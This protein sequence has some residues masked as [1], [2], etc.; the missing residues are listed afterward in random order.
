MRIP[1]VAPATLSVLRQSQMR[2]VLMVVAN[3]FG[4]QSLEVPNSASKLNKL[5]GTRWN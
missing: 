5:S 3:I 1:T 2:S 4:H